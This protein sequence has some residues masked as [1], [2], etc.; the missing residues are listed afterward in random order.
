[1]NSVKFQDKKL[2]Y[3]NLWHF[4]TLIKDYQKEIKKVILFTITSK[5]IK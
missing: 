3:R 5:R 4:Y 2:I 1:M